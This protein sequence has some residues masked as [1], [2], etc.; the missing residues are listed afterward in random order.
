VSSAAAA[1][2]LF[3]GRYRPLRPLGSGGMGHVWLARDEQSGL[4][5]SLKIV[6]REGKAGHRAEREARAAAS[7]RHPRCQRII[8]LASDSSHVYIAYEYIPGRTLREGLRAGE[9]DDRGAIEVAA[10]ISDALA[11][12]HRRGIVHRD[13]KPSNVLLAESD[14]IDVR[15]LDFGLAQM[16]EFDTLTALG[17]IP[18]TLAYI[19]PE[20]L[21]GLTATTAADIWGVGVL[22]WEA[23]AGEHP[24]WGGDMV[25]TSRRIQHG[26]PGLETV[27]PDLPRHVLDTVASALLVNPQRRP[28][29]ERL[30][31]EL[32]SLPKRRRKKGGSRP[33]APSLTR[34]AFATE[35]LLP[36]AL[37][38]LASGWVAARLPFYPAGW[39]LGI[40]ATGAAL[41]FTAPRAGLLFALAVAFFPLANISLGL[42]VLYA[43]LAAGWAALNWKDARAGLLLAA[44]PLLAPVAALGLVPLAAQAARGRA[45]RAAQ[46]GAAVLLAAL[47]A[48]LRRLPLP[49]D[50]SAP[51]LGLGVTGS[52][53]PSAVA[54]AFWGELTSHPVLIVEAL[55]LAAAAAALPH[56][57][58][59]GPWPAALFG[60]ALLAGTALAAPAAAVLPLVGAAWLT[61]GA[62]ALESQT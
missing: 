22:L 44:G 20:R 28:S 33:A 2:D 55:V 62:L 51:P 27:R 41:G 5:V 11:H 21:Q 9:L 13:V 26:A 45:R 6:A 3:L 31:Q 38:G 39:P 47:V 23:L 29:A 17:D 12:A 59:R 58:R 49:F 48:G 32:R 4:D 46:A 7:L 34:T 24:F 56:V 43:V 60:A 35:R 10:Q 50:G 57:R 1:H 19:S 16:A 36:G 52:G 30:A 14:R 40:A 15:L 37:A 18:G 8:S 54:H 25:E 53:R 42:A 61:A